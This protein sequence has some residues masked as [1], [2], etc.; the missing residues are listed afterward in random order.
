MAVALRKAGDKLRHLTA[1][2]VPFHAAYRG[3][4]GGGEVARPGGAVVVVKGAAL[5]GHS[6]LGYEIVHVLLRDRRT[7]HAPVLAALAERRA[8]LGRVGVQEPDGSLRDDLLQLLVGA[9]REVHPVRIGTYEDLALREDEID[10]LRKLGGLPL[11]G[12]GAFLGEL[13]YPH[14]PLHRVHPLRGDKPRGAQEHGAD[15]A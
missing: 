2:F 4:V 3:G 1:E 6:R 7:R 14:E 9:E 10:R 11:G 13:V 5:Y 12:Y 8:D 15:A